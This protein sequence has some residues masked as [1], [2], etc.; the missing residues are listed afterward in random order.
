[1]SLLGLWGGIN[2]RPYRGNERKL[3]EKTLR[4]DIEKTGINKIFSG[5]LI[6][7]IVNCQLKAYQKSGYSFDGIILE[8]ICS[9]I[10]RIINRGIEQ[11]KALLLEL[12]VFLGISEVLEMVMFLLRDKTDLN[13][14]GIS[15]IIDFAKR[16]NSGLYRFKMDNFEEAVKIFEA[17]F[18]EIKDNP[19]VFPELYF[20]SGNYLLSSLF[21]IF[22]ETPNEELADKIIS[23]YKSMQSHKDKPRFKDKVDFLTSFDLRFNLE[24]DMAK[25]FAAQDDLQGAM[26]VLRNFRTR[27]TEQLK[28]SEGYIDFLSLYASFF[29]FITS[30]NFVKF[31]CPWGESNHKF[32]YKQIMDLK[33]EIE[34]ILRETEDNSPKTLKLRITL[35][36]LHNILINYYKDAIFRITE[37]WE[38]VNLIKSINSMVEAG[39]HSISDND[40]ACRL[41]LA[42]VYQ[43]SFA[44]TVVR[45][46][47]LFGLWEELESYIGICRR[48]Y[49]T[50]DL[51]LPAI[52]EELRFTYEEVSNLMNKYREGEKYFINRNWRKVIQHLEKENIY[53]M[54]LIFTLSLFLIGCIALAYEKSKLNREDLV[55]MKDRLEELVEPYS[56]SRLLTES[57]YYEI[58]SSAIKILKEMI[59]Q[60]EREKLQV[61]QEVS[62]LSPLPTPTSGLPLS[63]L[64][65]PQL[66]PLLHT[67]RRKVP[68]PEP[69]PKI[70]APQTSEFVLEDFSRDFYNFLKNNFNE[71]II[72]FFFTLNN[73]GEA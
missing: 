3:L 34:R 6:N 10:T 9:A 25:L 21:S 19:S 42:S 44:N 60:Q 40:E 5:N 49:D 51:E 23:I 4:D 70:I 53:N 38:F 31:S 1:L 29:I 63:S 55:Q 27:Y 73:E 33:K 67:K 37:R 71:G 36:F 41:L 43:G 14:E 39:V 11:N 18:D 48:M 46:L 22:E 47:T 7:L 30:S 8:E 17:L 50:E 20:A 59:L 28:K 65:P 57:P 32:I 61:S 72:N 68:R 54:P 66:I 2:N 12:F 56:E 62:V 58:V 52:P 26:L 15:P 35:L 64:S 45:E 69:T 16:F 24:I 13:R